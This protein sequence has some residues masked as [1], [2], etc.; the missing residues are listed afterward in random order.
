MKFVALISQQHDPSISSHELDLSSNAFLIH[1]Q[2][3]FIEYNEQEVN[4]AERQGVSLFL[5]WCLIS[6]IISQLN[7]TQERIIR[8][9]QRTEMITVF[10][11]T[12]QATDPCSVVPFIV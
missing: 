3:S 11:W 2:K 9:Q 7:I 10:N 4:K 5:Q 8:R 6:S 12:F 1:R